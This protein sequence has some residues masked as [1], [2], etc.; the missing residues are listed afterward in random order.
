MCTLV[1]QKLAVSICQSVVVVYY[2]PFVGS[3]SLRYLR[4]TCCEKVI[5]EPNSRIF[6]ENAFLYIVFEI[7]ARNFSRNFWNFLTDNRPINLLNVKRCRDSPGKI[8]KQ[9]SGRYRASFCAIKG[10]LGDLVHDH[11]QSANF[12][13][14]F[15]TNN[16]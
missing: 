11:W 12:A 8:F 9:I 15:C 6:E 13:V 10:V 4:E 5:Q 7:Y 3:Y 16:I 1:Y 14:D 2:Y